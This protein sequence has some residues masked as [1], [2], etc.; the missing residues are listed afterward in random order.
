MKMTFPKSAK[1]TG[2]I[3]LG[4]K[5]FTDKLVPNCNR[6]FVMTGTHYKMKE[7]GWFA[8]CKK[9][10]KLEMIGPYETFHK[11]LRTLTLTKG[12]DTCEFNGDES[13]A[14]YLPLLD[15]KIEE[16]MREIF[17]ENHILSI[18]TGPVQSFVEWRKYLDIYFK[19]RFGIRLF[20]SLPDDCVAIVDSIK[21]CQEDRDFSMKIQALAGIIDRI[22]ENEIR[23]LI[24]EK[25]KQQLE[26]SINI[27]EQILKEKIPNY[28]QHAVSN[29]RNLMSLRSK[30]YPAHATSSELLVVLQNFGID[31]Y[32]LED[33][34]KGWIKILSLCS[35]SLRD[36]VKTLQNSQ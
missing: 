24:K 30:M 35:N 14:S 31:K 25:E 10:G 26:G 9:S 15:E 2:Q 36:L 5:V 6:C 20:K 3:V 13:K 21:P 33:W 27:L 34:Q 19:K 18:I 1:N 12:C 16:E 29:L 4:A 22:N 17:G 7:M 32:P 8:F 28:P 11:V 23:E